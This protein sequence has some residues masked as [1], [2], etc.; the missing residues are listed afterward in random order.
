MKDRN[1][2]AV[3]CALLA[4]ALYA[5]NVPLSKLLLDDVP[6]TYMAAFL[7]L[8]AGAGVGVLYAVHWRKE[9]AEERLAKSDLLYTA[10][11]ILLDILAPV[12]LMLGVSIGSA[13]NASLLGNFEIAATTLLALLLFQE[14]VS[15]KLWAAIA[16]I[17]VSSAILSFEGGGSF[18]FSRGSL[19]VLL[20][21]A[22]WGLENNCTRKLSEKSTYQIVTLK[23]FCCGG[24]SFL[25]AAMLGEPLPAFWYAA[26]AMLLGFAAYGL[27]IFTCIRA[28]R[29]LG[30]AKTSAYYAAAPFIG[31]FL[32]FLINGDRLTPAYLLAL[33]F[34]AVGTAFVISD[35][36]VRNHAHPHTH[37]LV[38]THDGTTHSHML[39]HTHEHRHIGRPDRHGRRHSGRE[40]GWEPG[41][42]HDS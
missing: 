34:M 2:R 33:A 27:S 6:P 23:G 8:G 28:Q 16:F 5:L 20:A 4:A 13:A 39:T 22:C 40:P 38:H 26:C 31:A 14:T 24:G 3:L 9:R 42:A 30:A 37:M 15:R 36:L 41:A 10:G 17:T 32:G 12:F 19:Y 18:Q 1:T 25:I 21:T 7:Y 35:T 11:M 29:A